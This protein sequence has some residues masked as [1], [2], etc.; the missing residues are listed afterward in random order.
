[1]VQLRD[2]YAHRLDKLLKVCVTTNKRFAILHLRLTGMPISLVKRRSD[3]VESR[4]LCEAVGY[5]A[6]KLPFDMTI[7]P[8][9]R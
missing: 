8:V 2:I 9:K 7:A 6:T 3:S 1:M 5:T 4:S